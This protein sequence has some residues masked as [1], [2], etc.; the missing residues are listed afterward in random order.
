MRGID[1]SPIVSRRSSTFTPINGARARVLPAISG[2]SHVRRHARSC[3]KC[4]CSHRKRVDIPPRRLCV[5][6]YLIN[7]KCPVQS[8][9][10]VRGLCS[11]TK[12][13]K[14]NERER[15]KKGERKEARLYEG[16]FF[17]CASL[18]GEKARSHVYMVLTV[19]HAKSFDIRFATIFA[20][21]C[22]T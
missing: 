9:R 2:R 6:V 18:D 16:I 14:P 22:N 8:C 4:R 17:E 1:R 10:Q 13:E 20:D 11:S 15:E 21:N 7:R 3:N 19:P 12:R 5:L